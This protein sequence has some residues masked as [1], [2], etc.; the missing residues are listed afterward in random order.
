MAITWLNDAVIPSLFMIPMEMVL[1]IYVVSLKN[2]TISKI[3]ALL[4]FG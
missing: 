3:A 1:V 4:P 2:W